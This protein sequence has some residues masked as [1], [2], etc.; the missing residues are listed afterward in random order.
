MIFPIF[1]VQLCECTKSGDKNWKGSRQIILS[2]AYMGSQVKWSLNVCIHNFQ[3]WKKKKLL[4]IAARNLPRDPIVTFTVS[5]K[6]QSAF[7]D[8][9]AKVGTRIEH[10]MLL[11]PDKTI[12]MACWSVSF[13]AELGRSSQ[14]YSICSCGTDKHF[15]VIDWTLAW[16]IHCRITYKDIMAV[17]NL[18]IY[19]LGEDSSQ[20]GLQT[21]WAHYSL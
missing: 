8:K 14:S 10:S 19:L 16:E 9:G 5:C 18:F 12:K 11:P 6:W 13:I 7:V 1:L 2:S 17:K 4:L 20:V 15:I 21:V 3:V